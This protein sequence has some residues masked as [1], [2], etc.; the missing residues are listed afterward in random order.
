MPAT[1]L[2]A[3]AVIERQGKLLLCRHDEA[4]Y[5]FFPGG[6]IEFGETA[7]VALRR[8][9]KEEA[10]LE[11]VE[12]KIIGG[13]ENIFE[14]WG[15]RHHEVNLVF[16]VTI[17]DVEVIAREPHLRFVWRDPASFSQLPVLP[18]A[19]AEAVMAWQDDQAMFWRSAVNL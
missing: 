14:A 13:V 3:R 17:R 8:E 18:Q 4:Q 10:S 15:R 9:L 5:F 11:V 1:E 6:H 12:A 2:I 7:E 19:M 16:M